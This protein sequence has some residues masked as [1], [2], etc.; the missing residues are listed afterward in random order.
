MKTGEL[1]S[2]YTNDGVCV[3]KWKDKPEVLGISTEWKANLENVVNKR[4]VEK[5]TS[6]NNKLQQVY[7]GSRSSRSNAILLPM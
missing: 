3:F 2:K 7:V 4:G 5:K 1:I 6:A